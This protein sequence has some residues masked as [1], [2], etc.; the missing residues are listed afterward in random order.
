MLFS[1]INTTAVLLVGLF[2]RILVALSSR[3]TTGVNSQPPASKPARNAKEERA[4]WISTPALLAVRTYHTSSH[5]H[6]LSQS[7]TW[8][9]RLYSYRLQ[10][11]HN[12][13]CQRYN[14][15]RW[16]FGIR[17]RC[18]R[19]YDIIRTYT[20]VYQVYGTSLVYWWWRTRHNHTGFYTDHQQHRVFHFWLF[21]IPY[22]DCS[23]PFFAHLR[24]I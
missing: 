14:N 19:M 2:C 11:V 21:F 20:I 22:L 4:W 15:L 1:T 5:S 24:M 10:Y 6:V 23:P 17:R 16:E 12:A 8:A 7:N 18:I 3:R 13:W 9:A